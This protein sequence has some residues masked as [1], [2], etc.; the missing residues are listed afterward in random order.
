[1]DIQNRRSENSKK[2]IPPQIFT[3]LDASRLMRAYYE[4]GIEINK[5]EFEEM[6]KRFQSTFNER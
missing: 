6:I 1:M 5:R 2:R 4:M 3:L